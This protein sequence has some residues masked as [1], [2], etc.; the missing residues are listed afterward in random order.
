MSALAWI[1]NKAFFYRLKLIKVQIGEFIF[2][3]LSQL[4]SINY[5]WLI[6][7]RTLKSERIFWAIRI[8]VEGLVCVRTSDVKVGHCI[9]IPVNLFVIVE[10]NSR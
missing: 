2:V 1:V 7:C 3:D 10:L 5:L 9:Y 4:N 8:N 6:Q